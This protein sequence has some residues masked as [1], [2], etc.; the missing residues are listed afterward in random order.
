MPRTPYRASEG[1]Q[2][3][4][5]PAQRLCI[6]P[7]TQ[8]GVQTQQQEVSADAVTDL[9]LPRTAME[10]NHYANFTSVD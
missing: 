2:N 9:S 3:K 7:V 4:G 5:V 8:S 6:E 10:F 1:K